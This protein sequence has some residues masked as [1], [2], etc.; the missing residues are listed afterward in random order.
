MVSTLHWKA[1]LLQADTNLFVSFSFMVDLQLFAIVVVRTWVALRSGRRVLLPLAKSTLF[2][3][4]LLT[5]QNV[6]FLVIIVNQVLV[7]AKL[8]L[9]DLL[10]VWRGPSNLASI[11]VAQLDLLFLQL[12]HKFLLLLLKLSVLQHD[13][14]IVVWVWMHVL[15]IELHGTWEIDILWLLELVISI[16]WIHGWVVVLLRV[17]GYL[18]VIILGRHGFVVSQQAW[19]VRVVAVQAVRATFLGLQL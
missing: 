12:K 13:L 2:T 16:V 19:H 10:K 3:A 11:I 5:Q 1:L 9:L 8:R 17:E 15:H 6:I 18:P 14:F 4:W 7:R